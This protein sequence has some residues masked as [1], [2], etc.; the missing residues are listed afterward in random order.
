M[1]SNPEPV[2]SRQTYDSELST[3]NFYSTSPDNQLEF[4]FLLTKI[5]TGLA[6][7]DTSQFD[8]DE[9]AAFLVAALEQAIEFADRDEVY[10]AVNDYRY[11]RIIHRTLMACSLLFSKPIYQDKI[12]NS[13]L[14]VAAINDFCPWTEHCVL[15]QLK[16]ICA[17]LQQQLQQ[18]TPVLGNGP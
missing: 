5:I 3:I 16:T 18:E 6:M 4:K 1:W 8:T 13:T 10:R 15:T 12:R 9:T 2:I 14:L 17:D 7:H 11:T